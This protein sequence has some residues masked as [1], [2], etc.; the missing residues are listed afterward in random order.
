[1]CLPT[2][3][4]SQQLGLLAARS[5]KPAAPASSQLPVATAAAA[6]A[7]KQGIK[8]YARTATAPGH[9]RLELPHT[10]DLVRA[11]GYYQT[12]VAPRKQRRLHE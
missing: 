9:T 11:G 12:V 5:Q 1:M 8:L 7:T 6:Q 10:F 4:T 2:A 3:A